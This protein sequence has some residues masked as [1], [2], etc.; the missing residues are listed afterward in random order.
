[1]S[2]EYQEELP[3]SRTKKKQMAKEVEK[4]AD[5]LSSMSDKAFGQLQL[6]EDLTVEV[7]EARET[8]GRSSH[9]RQVK[10]LAGYLRKQEDELL[11]LM[12]QLQNLD[13]V[14]RSEKHE[15][16]QLEKLRDRLCDAQTFET[17]FAEMLDLY[18]NVDRKA[19]SRLSRSVHQHGDKRA[20]REIFKRLRDMD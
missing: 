4:I 10:H 1:M 16:H 5:Q 9:K 8:K 18:P 6:S 12:T 2:E 20:Y 19:I 17:A 3:L 7:V 15:F 13:Q 11:Q 14:A